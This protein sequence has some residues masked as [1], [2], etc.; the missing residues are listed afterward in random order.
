MAFFVEK[1][2]VPYCPTCNKRLEEN[3][4]DSSKLDCPKCGYGFHSQNPDI[5]WKVA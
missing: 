4:E 3:C 5:V 2:E 1:R